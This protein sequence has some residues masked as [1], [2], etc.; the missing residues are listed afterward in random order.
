METG[1][2]CA[3]NQS[4]N[5][6][7]SERVTVV[8]ERLEPVQF[9]A[10]LLNG[11]AMD[12]QSS[13]LLRE[14]TGTSELPRL[15]AF[16]VAYLDDDHKII[17]AASVGPGTEFP[18]LPACVTSVLV[19]A[20]RRL[21]ETGSTRGNVVR[22]CAKAELASQSQPPSLSPSLPLEAQMQVQTLQNEA[23]A[24]LPQATTHSEFV[25]EPF[26]G[27]L[28]YLP[29][30]VRPAPQSSEYF[31]RFEVVEQP[32]AAQVQEALHAQA[33]EEVIAE[34]ILPKP[35]EEEE[36]GIELVRP[37][38]TSLDEDAAVPELP[39]SFAPTVIR[40]YDPAASADVRKESEEKTE[41]TGPSPTQLPPAL[42]AAILLMDEQLRREK[43]AQKERRKKDKTPEE[44]KRTSAKRRSSRVEGE[45]ASPKLEPTPTPPA[46]SEPA[47]AET[48]HIE[49]TQSVPAEAA[50]VP[51]EAAV[52]M[53][54]AQPAPAEAAVHMQSAQPV[55]VD[56]AHIETTEPAIPQALLQPA[57]EALPVEVAPQAVPEMTAV[58]PLEALVSSPSATEEARPAPVLEPEIER[59]EPAE[60]IPLGTDQQI[61]EA[62]VAPVL[63][64]AT[65]AVTPEPPPIKEPELVTEITKPE[66]PS[67]T[68]RRYREEK[69]SLGLRLQ[70]WLMGEEGAK[71]RKSERTAMP[72]LVAFYWSGG[73][74]KPHEVVNISKNGFYL[75]TKELWLPDTLVRMTLQRPNG[76]E[77][78]TKTS[79]GVL[80]RV[81]RID[82][83][84]VGHEFVTMET[85]LRMRT[86]DVLPE[87]ATSKKE[88][89][90]FLQIR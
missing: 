41:R 40:F 46:P 87:Q 29:D 35:A 58:P 80:A 47:T 68:G 53:E 26:V 4:A 33:A 23:E 74:P 3:Y 14:L 69:L 63:Q 51:P 71:R 42:K 44:K 49:V 17:E 10:L 88:L 67:R 50:S 30:A 81:V 8:C 5:E 77:G 6:L 61:E 86:R 2:Y 70:R 54:M 31:L 36:Q 13:V 83:D 18:A 57:P 16:D 89:E 21:E 11:P 75:R 39:V 90:K 1:N 76:D 72:G 12:R 60:M 85:L 64:A 25:F 65:V 48:Y 20:D 32:I 62:P 38:T 45:A 56:A 82:E 15:F 7:L 59:V 78:E 9:L 24:F 28:M 66:T 19:L 27:S 37:H 79:I 22:I 73:A 84:G 34:P 55:P 52:H 43:E